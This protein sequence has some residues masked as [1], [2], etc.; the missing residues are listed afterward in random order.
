MPDS[1]RWG[2]DAVVDG[3]LANAD[4]ST[5]AALVLSK[6]ENLTS[7]NIIV[8]SAGNVPTAVAM[9][10]DITIVAAGTTAIGSG[11]VLSAMI[12]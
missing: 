12:S 4:V 10:G 2:A 9:S 5:T 11:K 1:T 8:G 6:L 3:S 7:G